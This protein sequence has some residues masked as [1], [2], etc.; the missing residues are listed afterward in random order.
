MEPLDP[1]RLNAYGA[2][3]DYNEK[4][5]IKYPSDRQGK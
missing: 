4:P 1:L 5:Q 2:K 3:K